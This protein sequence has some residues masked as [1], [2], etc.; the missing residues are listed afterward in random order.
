M[1]SNISLLDYGEERQ[2]PKKE[3][4]EESSEEQKVGRPRVVAGNKSPRFQINSPGACQESSSFGYATGQPCVLVKMNK[5]KKKK[6][7]TKKRKHILF[8]CL[9]R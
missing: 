1:K 9:D 8:V 6:K 2:T 4:E 3:N 7:M 5:V